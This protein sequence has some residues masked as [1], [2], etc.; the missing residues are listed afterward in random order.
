[1]A[2]FRSRDVAVRVGGRVAAL[3]PYL[4]RPLIGIELDE[5]VGVYGETTLRVHVQLGDPAVEALRVELLVP[6]GIERVA[7]VHPAPVAAQFHHLRPP[8]Q[9]TGGR[10]R[11]LAND[12]PQM[13]GARVPGVER[14]GDIVLPHLS[15]TPTGDVE[16][17]VVEREV[18]VGNHG[19][20]R[21][22]V[23][24]SGRQLIRIRWLCRDV[25]HLLDTPPAVLAVPEP[26]R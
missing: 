19:R 10:V 7:E 5:E 16:E 9:G 8:V 20:H 6:G 1:M 22:E 26:Y 2:N 4:V 3:K 12:S 15:G 13:H 21:S 14:I 18:D 11:R 25:D 23:L 24:K 17:A